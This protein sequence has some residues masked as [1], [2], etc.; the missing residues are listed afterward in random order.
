A[1]AERPR[2]DRY[3]LLELVAKGGMGEV[4]LARGLGHA[5]FEKPVAVK[6]LPPELLGNR[7][8][9]K[10]FEDEARIA[11]RLVHP[12]IVPVFDFHRTGQMLLLAMEYVEGVSL[13]HVLRRVRD[14]GSALPLT[15]VTRIGQ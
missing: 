5:G 9:V 15:L 6:L 8:R 13:R 12:Y 11:A 1:P 10:R 4:W 7:Q 14:L 2:V 3:E